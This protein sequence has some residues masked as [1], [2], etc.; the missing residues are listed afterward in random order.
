MKLRK[1]LTVDGQ[2]VPLVDEDVRLDMHVPGRAM[3]RVQAAQPLQGFVRLYLGYSNQTADQLYFTGYVEK[4]APVDAQTQRLMCR[5]LTALMDV[6][7]PV[8]LRHPHLQDVLAAYAARTGLSFIMGK[9]AYAQRPVACFSALGS[10]HQGMASL[11]AVFGIDRYMWQQQGD[12]KVYVGSW[13]DSR[14]ATRPVT[15]AQD[16]FSACDADGGK[17]LPVLP[18]L[19]PGVLLNGEFIHS[20][21]LHGENMVVTCAKQYEK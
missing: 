5:E 10:G 19:R 11:G 7:M 15:V 20:L 21:K 9:G 4:S 8:F 12:D 6:H 14:W 3:F 18:A 16:W 13:N 17:T 1:R 2:Q